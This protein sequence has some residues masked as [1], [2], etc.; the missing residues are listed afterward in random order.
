MIPSVIITELD[1]TLGVLPPSGGRLHAIVGASSAGATNSPATFARVRDLQAAFGAGPLVEAAAHYIETYGRPVI[2]VRTGQSVAGANGTV[3]QTGTGTSDA[4][5]TGTAADDVDVYVRVTTGGTIG[6]AGIVVQYS[7]DGGRTLSPETALGVAT[8]LSVGSGTLAA[9]FAAGTLVAG[10]TVAFRSTAPQWNTAE[11]T[12]ALTA[13]RVSAASWE[14]CQVVGAIDGNAFD[15]LDL[16]FASMHAAAKY[17]MWIGNCRVPGAGESE[18]TY[19]SAMSTIFGSRSS[20]LG[21]LCAGAE[22]LTSSVSGRKYRRP[23]SVAVAARIAASSEEIDVAHVLTGALRG[24]SIRDDAGNPLEHDE[25][26]NPGLDDA[27]FATL[28]TWEARQGVYVTNPRVFSATGSDF[29]F[30]QHRR[31]LNLAHGVVYAALTERL[32]SPI[33]VDRRTGFILEEEAREIE[34]GVNARL[35]AVLLAKPKASDSVFV[36][37]RSDNLLST[38]TLTGSCRVTPL[39]YPKAI[40]IEVGFMNP[41]L[42]VQQA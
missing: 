4:T 27:R 36:V 1:G 6:T 24:V 18:A 31:V 14:V 5:A 8:S 3:A 7:L 29:E 39:A 35:R 37:S 42:A 20:V 11:L 41:A 40:E 33:R 10:D 25:S 22:L 19:L 15:A 21:V 17:T 13:L 16:A 23:V 26:A 34:Q 32:S 38:K 30:A 28:R 2:V 12:S 9:A